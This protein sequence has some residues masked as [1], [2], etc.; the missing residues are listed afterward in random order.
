MNFSYYDMGRLKRGQA[1]EVALSGSAA[2]VLLLDSANYCSRPDEITASTGDS[3]SD[4][5]Y[6]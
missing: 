2:N 1:I 6:V 4:L 3:P 5:R